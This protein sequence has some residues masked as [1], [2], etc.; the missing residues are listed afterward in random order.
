MPSDIKRKP[1]IPLVTDK[2]VLMSYIFRSICNTVSFSC[3]AYN[4]QRD[5]L[6]SLLC[7]TCFSLRSTIFL[8]VEC[9]IVQFTLIIPLS[10]NSF[11]A[12]NYK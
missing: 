11:K 6:V 2:G 4:M 12:I 10:G 8:K 7:D 1:R 9:V 3:I 5:K